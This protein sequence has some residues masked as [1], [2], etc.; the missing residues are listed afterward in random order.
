LRRRS[1]EP[2]RLDRSAAEQFAAE[3]GG[4]VFAARGGDD[5]VEAGAEFGDVVPGAVAESD[6]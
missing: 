4:A 6:T 1:I 3:V 5:D 2:Q